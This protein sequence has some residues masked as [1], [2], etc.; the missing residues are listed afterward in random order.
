MV[1]TTL[2]FLV[3]KTD[4]IKNTFTVGNVDITLTE[5]GT[6]G[7]PTTAG[8]Q[9]KMIP[10]ETYSKDPKV[11]VVGGSE[12]CWVFVKIDKS[13]NVDKFLEF[14]IDDSSWTQLAGNT[15]VYWKKVAASSDDQE[16]YVLK[17]N[18]VTISDEID[19][20]DLEDVVT[21]PILTFTAYAVQQ[22]GFDTA[23]T[24]AENAALAWAEAI[25]QFPL[26]TTTP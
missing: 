20:E 16:F 21:G 15:D 14:A 19:K 6:D 13:N 2:A 25:A 5:T 8:N 11:K 3:D 12:A 9:Y 26:D 17:G 4:S 23:A 22:D 10:G 1:G 18:T 7:N 24:D